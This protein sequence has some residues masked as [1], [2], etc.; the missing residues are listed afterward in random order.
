MALE[1]AGEACVFVEDDLDVGTSQKPSKNFWKQSVESILL[2][3][4]QIGE[5]ESTKFRKAGSL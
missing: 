2:E 4:Q 1:A 5:N 3:V